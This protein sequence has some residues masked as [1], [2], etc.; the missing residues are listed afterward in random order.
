MN[1]NKD[2]FPKSRKE[3]FRCPH[4]KISAHQRWQEDLSLINLFMT[5]YCEDLFHSCRPGLASYQESAIRKFLDALK[6]LYISDMYS[7][8]HLNIRHGLSTSKCDHCGKYSVWV[9]EE[10]IYPRTLW[11]P[12]P[13]EDM[14]DKVKQIYNEAREIEQASPRAA[15][16]LLRV[17]LEELLNLIKPKSP[18]KT[19]YDRVKYLCQEKVLIPKPINVYLYA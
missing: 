19:L 9:E 4:C 16:A 6:E 10:L 11:M 17:A 5:V 3:S 14:P 7:N 1:Q 12:E 18:G 2:N 8:N 15:A 13:A